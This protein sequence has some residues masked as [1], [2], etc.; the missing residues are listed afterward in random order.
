MKAPNRLD[1][2]LNCNEFVAIFSA[3]LMRNQH[4]RRG[5]SSLCRPKV[6]LTQLYC[7]VADKF[8][9]ALYKVTHKTYADNPNPEFREL[10]ARLAT[11][12]SVEAAED[13]DER[14][15]AGTARKHLLKY[16]PMI[17]YIE[18]SRE[19]ITNIILDDI[20][21]QERQVRRQVEDFVPI[22]FHLIDEED[23]FQ[24]YGMLTWTEVR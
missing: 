15:I 12:A 5:A 17:G 7:F 9:R 24:R 11:M 20:L 16:Q 8:F 3:Q 4:E 23:E 6:L 1:A 13:D 19:T 18:F 14:A 21:A 2:G 22:L 10:I